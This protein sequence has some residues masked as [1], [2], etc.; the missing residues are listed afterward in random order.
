M[1]ADLNSDWRS[2]LAKI[3]KI[4]AKQAVSAHA[5]QLLASRGQHQ[6]AAAAYR[7]LLVQQPE[8]INILRSFAGLLQRT[9]QHKQ[10]APLLKKAV[11]L[12]AEAL[13]LTA[14]NQVQEFFAAAEHISDTPRTAPA[15]FVED[16]FDRSA[17]HF[18]E[19]L[20][21]SLEYRA[22]QVLFNAVSSVLQRDAL[23]VLDLGCGTGLAGV[24]FK[25]LAR[26]LDGVDLSSGMIAKAREKNIYAALY[27]ADITD[28]LHTITQSY[29]LII[30]VDVL[31][32]LGDLQ[33]VLNACQ[34][35]LNSNG[36]LAFTLED[37]GEELESGYWLNPTRRYSHAR[38]Y[39]QKTAAQAGFS[40]VKFERAIVRQESL[41]PVY[42]HVCIFCV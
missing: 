24:C 41:Q 35:R 9:G 1:K 13:G 38:R 6:A 22:P 30:A 16:L 25:P 3:D 34:Q 28:H 37:A 19:L 39:V 20:L 5:A 4:A 27:V 21:G 40:E 10:A 8:N 31:N 36:M 18:E 12:E 42:A 26:I 7:E 17:D 15:A 32:Y 23:T 29:D 33:P 14:D 11:L 2:Q